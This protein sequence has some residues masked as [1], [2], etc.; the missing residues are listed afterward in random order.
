MN[1]LKNT[2]L[3]NSLIKIVKIKFKYKDRVKIV[4]MKVMNHLNCIY[5]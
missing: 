5:L 3:F 2:I 1:L 4:K